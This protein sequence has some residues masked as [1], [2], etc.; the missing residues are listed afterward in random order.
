MY[1]AF[2]LNLI[3]NSI[4]EEIQNGRKQDTHSSSKENYGR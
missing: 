3:F 2:I 4:K 1:H